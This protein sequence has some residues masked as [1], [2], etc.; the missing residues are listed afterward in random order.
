MSRTGADCQDTLKIPPN[1]SRRPG[2]ALPGGGPRRRRGPRRPRRARAVGPRGWRPRSSWNV[3]AP[4]VRRQPGGDATRPRRPGRGG[5][6]NAHTATPG[7]LAEHL[8]VGWRST[9]CTLS[10]V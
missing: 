6:L 4:G 7:W 1:R 9:S 5:R 8:D 3:P 10:P 2:R